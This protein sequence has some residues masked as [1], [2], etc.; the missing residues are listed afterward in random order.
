M[1]ELFSDLPGQ[2]RATRRHAHRA[3][4]PGGATRFV[5]LF[6]AAALVL[7]AMYLG[8]RTVKPMYDDWRAPS[9][10]AGPGSGEV[11]VQVL[12]G[13]SGSQVAQTLV[14]K[15]VIKTTDAFIEA[16]MAN[17]DSNSLQPGTYALRAE[18]AAADALAMLL[19]E[20][21]GWAWMS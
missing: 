4:R 16:S 2:R 15:N 1:T 8:W 3:R 14:D 11:H 5:V 19:D 20:T 21:K 9:D 12:A 10:F 17:P 13:D 6:L 18:M 7:G